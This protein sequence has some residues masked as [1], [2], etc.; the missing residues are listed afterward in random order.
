M[1]M[2]QGPTAHVKKTLPPTL[3]GLPGEAEIQYY[4]KA[5]VQRP[6]FYKENWRNTSNFMFF[7]IEPPRPPPNRREAYARVQHQFA[8]PVDSETRRESLWRK[9]VITKPSVGVLAPSITIEGRL[10]DP[11]IITCNQALPLRI[12]VTRK[13]ESTAILYLQMLH[14]ELVAFTTIRAQQLRRDEISNWTIL[15]TSNM[16]TPFSESS[17]SKDPGNKIIEV[18]S[19]LWKQRP[20]PNNVSPTF[21]TCNI[22]RT[23]ALHIKVGVSWGMEGE[24]IEV[25]SPVS[26][27]S[28][29]G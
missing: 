10:P 11:P 25:C 15:S 14:I 18:P 8:P 17:N 6:A 27:S 20:L 28:Q 23:Y 9:K 5:T 1:D 24:T 4:I 16:K 2:T 7:P 29:L 12:L 26:S 22:S 3:S 19:K 21:H 13:N